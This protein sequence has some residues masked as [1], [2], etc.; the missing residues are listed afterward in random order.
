MVCHTNPPSVMKDL[1]PHLLTVLPGDLSQFY[2]HFGLCL[3]LRRAGF[4]QDQSPCQEFCI[5]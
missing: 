2:T 3:Q 4:V 1:F 5:Q